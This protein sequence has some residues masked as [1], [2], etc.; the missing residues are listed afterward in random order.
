MG[1]ETL[2]YQSLNTNTDGDS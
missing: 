1:L 2:V